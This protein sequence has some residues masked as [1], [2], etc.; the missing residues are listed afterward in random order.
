MGNTMI[1]GKRMSVIKKNLLPLLFVLLLS[2]HT[3]AGEIIVVAAANLAPVMDE[4]KSVF[5]K[6]SHDKIKIV[7]GSSGKLTAQIEN[8]APFDV[9]LS[10]DTEYPEILHKKKLTLSAPK[11]YAYGVLVLWTTRIKDLSKGITILSDPEIKKIAIA[12]PHVAPYGRET[13]KALE[14]CKIY[15]NIE[16]KLV[17][18]ESIAQANDFIVSGSAD[19]GFTSKSSVLAPNLKEKGVWIE[20]PAEAYSRIAQSAVILNHARESDMETAKKFYELL[21]SAQAGEIF[22]KYGYTVHE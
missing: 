15:Q 22:R 4:F 11:V 7:I 8:G 13:V 1:T 17:Y 3:F 6:G 10:A 14:Y 12:N 18:G 16:K 20:I 19:I 21:Y 2:R 5:E 9:F